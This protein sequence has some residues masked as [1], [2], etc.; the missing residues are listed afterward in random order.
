L[1]FSIHLL[2]STFLSKTIW[3]IGLLELGCGS[4]RLGSRGG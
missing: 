2:I 1:I 4:G 3:N